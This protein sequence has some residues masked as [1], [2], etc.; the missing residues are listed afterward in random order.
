[1][2][3]HTPIEIIIKCKNCNKEFTFKID[4]SRPYYRKKFC[5]RDCHYTYRKLNKI[6]RG[7][8]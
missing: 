4:S 5:S 6:G 1:M 7:K 8:C 2:I 3:R